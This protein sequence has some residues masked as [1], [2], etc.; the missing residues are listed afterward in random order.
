MF[1]FVSEQ[2]FKLGLELIERRNAM[3]SQRGWKTEKL[4]T[5]GLSE[6]M[7]EYIDLFTALSD[8]KDRFRMAELGAGTAQRTLIAVAAAKLMRPEIA[9]DFVAVEAMPTHVDIARQ[10]IAER[11]LEKE[12]INLMNAAVWVDDSPSFFPVATGVFGQSVSDTAIAV[13]VG[14]LAPEAAKAALNSLVTTGRLGIE[15]SFGTASGERTRDWAVI[16]SLTPEEIL[17]GRGVIDLVDCDI[18]GAERQVLPKF[19]SLFDDHVKL[20]HIGTH[21]MEM[22]EEL[23]E[24]FSSHDWEIR[25]SLSPKTKH[26]MAFGSVETNDGVLGVRN[27]RAIQ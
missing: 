11:G 16:S 6:S 2:P 3:I 5:D 9:R 23:H 4:S 10:R 22:H 21:G 25:W 26:E 17:G 13:V 27:T 24:L 20:M 14:K 8:A 12:H 18:Q 1:S 7:L 19:M 15:E